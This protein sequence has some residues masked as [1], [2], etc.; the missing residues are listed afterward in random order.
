MTF[1]EQFAANNGDPIEVDGIRISPL[2]ELS[3]PVD[4]D[5]RISITSSADWAVQGI[6]ARIRSGEMS[7]GK[8]RSDDFVFWH[9]T[10]PPSFSVRIWRASAMTRV[11]IRNIWRSDSGEIV[12][13]WS[14]NSGMIVEGD[15]FADRG[16]IFRCASLNETAAMTFDDVVF[17]A[18]V[19]YL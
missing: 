18:S 8:T 1:K 16:A 19:N 7:V 2:Y 13:A 4:A 12:H 5:L 15:P 17:R 9:D 10:A 3:I 6:R 11:R 14:G